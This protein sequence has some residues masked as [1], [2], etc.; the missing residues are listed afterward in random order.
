MKSRDMGQIETLGRQL[1]GK[2]N[3]NN[4]LNIYKRALSVNTYGYLLIDLGPNTPEILQLRTNI[5]G[6]TEY[7]IIYQ[8]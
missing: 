8:W 2:G 1:Y 4:F 3:G 7:Q 5:L 6:E